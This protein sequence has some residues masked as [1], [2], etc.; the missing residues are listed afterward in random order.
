MIPNLDSFQKV[1]RGKICLNLNH[2]MQ[3]KLYIR[4]DNKKSVNFLWLCYCFGAKKNS[5]GWRHCGA[6][7]DFQEALAELDQ[8][9]G[10]LE[11]Y[12]CLFCLDICERSLRDVLAMIP[13]S[14]HPM[15][16]QE[17]RFLGDYQPYQ[18]PPPPTL[19][20]WLTSS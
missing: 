16:P 12:E 10:V 15:H 18:S 3:S 8:L 20:D 9:V 2:V 17:S 6:Q 14:L 7:A 11:P 1:G 4:N 19:P 5:C 13:P